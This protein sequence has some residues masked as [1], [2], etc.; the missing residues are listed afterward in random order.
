MRLINQRFWRSLPALGPASGVLQPPR[1]KGRFLVRLRVRDHPVNNYRVALHHVFGEQRGQRLA[2]RLRRAARSASLTAFGALARNHRGVR[3]KRPPSAAA[4]FV[5]A[6]LHRAV[7]R[8]A[9]AFARSPVRR[10]SRSFRCCASASVLAFRCA[11]S[12]VAGI[13]SGCSGVC[14]R[15]CHWQTLCHGRSA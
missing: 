3:S 6:L 15:S 13:A 12:F 11:V 10:Q 8:T 14:F 9:D 1:L 2:S 4:H 7:Y 5:E